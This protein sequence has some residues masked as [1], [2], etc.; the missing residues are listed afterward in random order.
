MPIY[1]PVIYRF[2]ATMNNHLTFSILLGV[3]MPQLTVMR[4][5]MWFAITALA[6]CAAPSLQA[7]SVVQQQN[8]GVDAGVD[9]NLGQAMHADPNEARGR[10][11]FE[12][13]CQQCHR[14]KAAGWPEKQV[15]ALAGQQFAYLVKQMVDFL[16]RARPN[17]TMHEQAIHS[18]MLNAQRIADVMAYVANLPPAAPV[19]TGPGSLLRQGQELYRLGCQSCHGQDARGNA[20]LWAPSLRDQHYSYLLKQMQTMTERANISE[21]L[22]HVFAAYQPQ[23]LQAVADWLSQKSAP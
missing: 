10:R 13:Y 9:V 20:D 11:I 6:L 3:T 5:R 22:H 21:D 17:D 23:Q 2:H 12:R 16:D 4:Y 7:R 15:P 18:G 19:Q 1:K 14:A 8:H